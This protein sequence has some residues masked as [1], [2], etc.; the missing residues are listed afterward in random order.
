MK[1]F[2]HKMLFSV[3]VLLGA[4]AT[5]QAQNGELITVAPNSPYPTI[6]AALE[7]AQDGDTIEVHG[8]IYHDTPLDITKN[9]QLIGIDNPVIDAG[10]QGTAVIISADYVL[11]KGFTIRNTGTNNS[12]EDSGIV[13]QADHVTVEDNLLENVL[14]GIY[15]A[16]AEYG[17]A[18]HNIVRGYD[19][20]LARRGDG[21]RVWFSQHVLLENNLVE[22]SRDMLIWYADDVTIIGNTFRNNR[23]GLHFMYSD[24]AYIEGNH[25]TGNSVG[26]YLMYSSGLTVIG[27]DLSYNRG[28]S[29]YGIALKDMDVVLMHDNWLI[30]NRIG[31]YLDNSPALYEGYNEFY[32]N[33]FAY[34]DIGITTLPSVERNRFTGNTFL[35][36]T[37]QTAVNG[38]GNML[39]NSWT[40][41]GQ[42][43]YWSDYA[44]YDANEDGLGDMPYRAEKLFENLTDNHP[45]LRFFIYSPAS[46]AIDLAGSAF[47]SLRPNPRLIDD[48]PMTV[49]QLPDDTIVL[50]TQSGEAP[51]L[52]AVL[53]TLLGC[54]PFLTLGKGR[55]SKLRPIAQISTFDSSK[56]GAIS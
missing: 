44:G 23:Y 47:P 46:Q 5:V 25:F 19:L 50:E 1:R 38:R 53:L 30:G 21:M 10:G 56:Q 41:E 7:I 49:Y 24:N 4:L 20:E 2:I 37:Q 32:D 18:R 6:I 26:T 13:I 48:V 9:V 27:N 52:P 11:L 43:N 22:I 45:S 29:G 34:N 16:D 31:L 28:P 8:G 17:T 33:V 15:F 42:G 12:H 55:F 36:N 51:L 39:G 40:V 14:F 35:E 3:L 54:L